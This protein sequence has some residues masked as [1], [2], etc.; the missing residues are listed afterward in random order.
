MASE[1][2]MKILMIAV[3]LTIGI[4]LSFQEYLY[5]DN[6]GYFVKYITYVLIVCNITLSLMAAVNFL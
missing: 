2:I 4:I 1:M 6:D 3:P 5:G